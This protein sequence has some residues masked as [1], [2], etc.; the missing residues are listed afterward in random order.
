M[1]QRTKAA[2]SQPRTFRLSGGRVQAESKTH[3]DAQTLPQPAPEPA[4]SLEQPPEVIPAV[5]DDAIRLRAYFLW[6][7]AGCPEGDGVNYW[8]EA[9]REFSTVN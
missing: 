4:P 9:E 2:T 5:T 8:T 6:E 3:P 7:A 1:L